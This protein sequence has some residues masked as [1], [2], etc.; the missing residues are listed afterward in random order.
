VAQLF[1]EV[2]RAGNAASHAITGD[3]RSALASLRMVAHIPSFKLGTWLSVPAGLHV[4]ARHTASWVLLK[5]S[6]CPRGLFV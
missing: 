6:F 3:H 1:G 2:R 4:T 5:G